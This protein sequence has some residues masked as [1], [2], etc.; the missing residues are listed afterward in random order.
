MNVVIQSFASNLSDLKLASL[1]IANNVLIGSFGLLVFAVLRRSRSAP[2]RARERRVEEN[3]GPYLS[4][5]NGCLTEVLGR[6]DKG[7]AVQWLESHRRRRFAEDTKKK[8]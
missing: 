2:Y 8:G 5:D 4:R 7:L 6:R 3:R 1:S